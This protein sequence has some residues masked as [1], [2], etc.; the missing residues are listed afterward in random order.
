[1]HM[2]EKTWIYYIHTH[3]HTHMHMFKKLLAAQN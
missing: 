2:F 1:M 3:M